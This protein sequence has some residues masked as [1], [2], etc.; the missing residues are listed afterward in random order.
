MA[1]Y[2]S[3]IEDVTGQNTFIDPVIESGQFILPVS[4]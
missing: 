1:V 2:S 3:T 4:S